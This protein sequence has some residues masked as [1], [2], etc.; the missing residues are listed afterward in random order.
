M[1]PQT[2]TCDQCGEPAHVKAAS[3]IYGDADDVRRGGMSPQG[4]V[5]YSCKIE[6]PTCGRRTQVVRQGAAP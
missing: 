3:L 4:V 5:E 6:C 1:T 2:V